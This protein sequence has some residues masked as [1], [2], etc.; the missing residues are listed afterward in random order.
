[1][2]PVEPAE[3][4]VQDSSCRGFRGVP[5]FFKFPQD[6]GIKGVDCDF[7]N[8]LQSDS[9]FEFSDGVL[10][11]EDM[12]GDVMPSLRMHVLSFNIIEAHIL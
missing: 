10:S 2:L 11:R 6:W 8:T 1:V 7:S 4:E 12:P 9:D 3:D 5:Y